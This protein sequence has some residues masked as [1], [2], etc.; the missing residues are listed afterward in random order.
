ML[1]KVSG[2]RPDLSP[3]LQTAATGDEGP[4]LPR[5]R[6][7]STPEPARQGPPR[8]AAGAGG[9]RVWRRPSGSDLTLSMLYFSSRV[10]T[11][12]PSSGNEVI[13]PGRQDVFERT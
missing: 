1:R 4:C 5:D 3:R 10:A 7:H 13:G 8:P 12:G 11:T 9:C 2:L 6:P